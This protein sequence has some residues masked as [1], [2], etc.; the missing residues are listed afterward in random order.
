MCVKL[1]KVPSASDLQNNN[2]NSSAAFSVAMDKSK[3]GAPWTSATKRGHVPPGIHSCNTEIEHLVSH[4][5]GKTG[6][7][8]LTIL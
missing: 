6:G 7:D 5:T 2:E 4:D 8:I 3:K 1:R